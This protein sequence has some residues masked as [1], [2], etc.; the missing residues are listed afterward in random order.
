LDE[1]L[2]ELSRCREPCGVGGAN[3]AKGGTPHHL[4]ENKNYFNNT[5]CSEFIYRLIALAEVGTGVGGLDKSG[6][7]ARYL[8]LTDVCVQRCV[9]SGKKPDVDHLVK[10]CLMI[11]YSL[12]TIRND[13]KQ[14]I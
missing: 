8:D 3:P 14:Q 9:A 2:T 6:D 1:A 12:F 13:R 4:H 10:T 11:D 7:V 5:D